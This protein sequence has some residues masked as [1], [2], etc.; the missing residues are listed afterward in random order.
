YF[1]TY[2]KR[3][4][5]ELLMVVQEMKKY[6]PA[7]RRS[8]PSTL[9]ALNYALRCVRSVQANSEFFQIHNLNRAP[10]R[11]VT[12]YSLKELATVAS[13][14]TSK[15]TDTFV[16]VFSFLSGRLVH[17][18]E[19]AALIL[20][21]K[22]DFLKSSHFVDLLAPQD[23]RVFYTHTAR[24]QL[25]FWNSWTQRGN[26]TNVGMCIIGGGG[27]EHEK[28][29]SPF[30]IIPYLVHVHSSTQ[31][32]SEPCCLTLVEKIH[33]GY[34]APRIPVDKRI[35]TTTH[36]PGCV[37][38][39]IDERAVPLL[40][41][42]PQDL[43]GTSVLACLHP[44]DRP[45]MV[46]MHQKVLKYAGHPPFEH[47]P[48][49]FCT[50]NGD[51]VILDSSWSSFVNPWSRKVSFIIGRHKVRT[52]PL[53]EDVFATR[54]KKTNS[55]EKDITELQEQIHKL[56]LQP[57]HGS[58]SS[59]YGS[60]GSSGSQEHQVSVDSSSE[61]SRHCM[62]EVQKEPMTLKQVYSSVNKVKNLGQQLY[63]DS[64]ARS[65]VKPVTGT[66]PEPSGGDEQ[67]ASSS[68][69]TLKNK[70]TCTEFCE[71]LR[72]D[73]H[74]SS[75]QQMNCIDSVIRYLKSYHIP[76]LKRKCVSST[77][78]MASSSEKEK[79]SHQADDTQ[80]VQAVAQTPA[81][82][83]PKVPTNGWP[84]EAEAD[85][86]GT[87][88]T[89]TLSLGSGTSQCSYSSTIVHVPPPEPA[90]DAALGCEP[91]TLNT[92]PAPFT[93]EEFKHVGLTT[94][95]LSAHTQREEQDYVDRFRKKI[96]S[97]PYS[98]CLHRE[99]SSK[100]RRSCVQ[101]DFTSKQSRLAGCRKG[102]HKRTKP[103]MP[104]GSSSSSDSFRFQAGGPLQD[105]LPWCPST[106]SS[107]CASGLGFPAA[108]MVP[109]QSSYLLPA[110]PLP[111]WAATP[112]CP[113]KPPVSSGLQ[114]LPALP[115]LHVD[116][117]MTFFLHDPRICPLWSPSF[118]PYPFLGATDSSEIPPSVSAMAPNLEPPPS[119]NSQRVEEKWEMQ[120]EEHLFI[121]SRSSSPLQLDLLH[122]DVPVS[123]EPPDAVRRDAGPEHCVSGGGGSRSSS[124]AG[125]LSPAPPHKVSPS[126]AGSAASGSGSG[127]PLL[128]TLLS[129]GSAG[130][131]RP[132]SPSFYLLLIFSGSTGSCIFF[133]STDHSSESSENERQSQDTQKTNAFHSLA[134]DPI[135]KMIAQTPECV[136]MTYQVP[137]RVKEVVLK[138]D[139]EKLESLRQ[140][141]FSP[142][143]KEE[144][145]KVH[146]WIQSQ[147]VPRGMHVQSCAT[148]EDRGSAGD[149]A[150]APG[151]HP[152]EDSS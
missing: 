38:L 88:S 13:E 5:E 63:I 41:Y 70:C 65:S 152:G 135:W 44:E 87:L 143:Q 106:P 119:V 82:P 133:T 84:T 36:T 92:Q 67:K 147:T 33:S 115:S 114:H 137:E 109:S 31:P 37:F 104:L 79:P 39:E 131:H 127:K 61:S 49:R 40:G 149:T 117:L 105:V 139:L 89:A 64:M 94:A 72:K 54:I 121:S 148:C 113:P 107:A 69:P 30:R 151:P 120:K 118:S 110:F 15:N 51:Y 96:L 136:L 2:R 10:E 145:A 126:G 60:L 43:T 78:T 6:F 76:A 8:K 86:A 25:P 53:N 90:E 80:A 46:T 57:I 102:K 55:N 62:E 140:P 150:E 83:Q 4:S 123:P 125:D 29:H 141:Q 59:G 116:T 3:V 47:S 99:S 9:D 24:A 93:A 35:F 74:S 138:E 1:A 16:A 56:L 12:V 75:Y 134:E 112:E 20:N 26:G 108:V 129:R 85:L 19:Q 100:A 48:I 14:H 73:Q 91:W 34:E 101:G 132:G 111:A 23:L 124:A 144:L 122:E 17:I 50:Q 103:P 7:E 32:E 18:S 28:H 45:L 68:S 22:K 11:E 52:S 128:Q 81:M 130:H 71:D 142:G 21:C 58:T 42:L 97:S 27:R 77:N 66:R 146:P 98:C 95:S